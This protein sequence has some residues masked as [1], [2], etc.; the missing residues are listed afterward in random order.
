VGGA[1]SLSLENVTKCFEDGPATGPEAESSGPP[2]RAAVYDVSLDVAGGEIVSLLG[3]SGCGKTTILRMVAGLESADSGRI[4]LDEVDLAAT[5]VHERGFGL[6]F[7]EF[8]LFPDKTVAQNVAFGLRMAGWAREARMARVEEMLELVGLEGYGSRTIFALSGGERQRV[9]LARSLAPSPRLLMLD[10]PWGS[11][12][13][14]LREG[15][16]DEVRRILKR[17]QIT[18]LYVTHDQQE[19]LAV[20]DRVAVLRAGRLQQVAPPRELFTQP[21]NRF[22]AQ[23]LGFTNLLPATVQ[24]EDRCVAQT[25]LGPLP[26]AQ[27]AAPGA[28]LLLIRPTALRPAGEGGA[29]VLHG[30]V[31]EAH[32]RGLTLH[33][34]IDVSSPAEGAADPLRL[35]FDVAPDAA[36]AAGSEIS[37]SLDPHACTVVQP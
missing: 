19:A 1:P 13:R 17:L 12:D 35:A 15:L 11:L 14:V 6:M 36:P 37:F 7:Q 31:R 28:W 24:A 22:V 26:L 16:L 29:P 18:T 32:F 21:A 4:L 30:V 23:F 3:P 2:R 10:E 27:E 9:A 20:S 8:A 25:A 34:L 33:V 5:P